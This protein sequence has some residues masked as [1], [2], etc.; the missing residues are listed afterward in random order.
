HF[1]REKLP[2]VYLALSPKGDRLL[3]SSLGGPLRLLEWPTGKE[4]RSWRGP[5]ERPSVESVALSPDGRWAA[6]AGYDRLVRLFRVPPPEPG[7]RGCYWSMPWA[8]RGSHSP[9]A[10]RRQKC[11]YGSSS[12]TRQSRCSFS[13]MMPSTPRSSILRMLSLSSSVQ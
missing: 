8:F 11:R 6:S 2:A 5:A 1:D 12:S 13:A 10:A 7:G 3:V 9:G 4:L